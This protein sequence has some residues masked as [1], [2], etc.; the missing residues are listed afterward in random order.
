MPALAD[1]DPAMQFSID[2][3]ILERFPG[4]RIVAAVAHGLDNRAAP[5]GLDPAWIE[6]WSR[7]GRLDLDD[8]RSHPTVAALRARFRDAGVSMKR[9]PTSI[10]AMLRRALKGGEPFRINPLV[11]FY[12]TLSMR[13]VLPAG[14]FDLAT[15]PGDIDLRFTREGDR[16]TALDAQAPIEVPAGEIA[17][18]S[19]QVV[20]TRHFMWRQAREALVHPH[21]SEVFLVSEVPAEAGEDAAR[22]MLADMSSGLERFFGVTP[23]T[24]VLDAAN[25]G[26]RW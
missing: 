21:T 6:S 2:P 19:A 9:F 8:A 7:A 18:A 10:E 12:N 22:E 14:A 4:M 13:H 11:D 3:A 15:L 25:P 5:D 16:F 1:T 24:F 17:Y 20:L 23:H 26:V